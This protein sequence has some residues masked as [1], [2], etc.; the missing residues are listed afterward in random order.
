MPAVTVMTRAAI[1]TTALLLSSRPAWSQA[2]DGDAMS[3]F[4]SGLFDRMDLDRDGTLSRA[5]H[6][7]THGGGFMVDYELLDLDG[8]GTVSREE[9]L[10]AVR[11]YHPPR[12]KGEA[13]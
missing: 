8:S 12:P 13:I 9:Y 6:D 11:K 7:A 5:E 10:E 2:F 4:A 1:L 3:D